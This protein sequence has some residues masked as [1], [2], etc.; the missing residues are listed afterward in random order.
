MQETKYG[1]KLAQE[2]YRWMIGDADLGNVLA[3]F[4]TS[5]VAPVSL[6][7]A[8]QPPLELRSALVTLSVDINALTQE[9]VRLREALEALNSTLFI[10]GNSLAPKQ[11]DVTASAPEEKAKE[12]ADG[13]VMSAIK[14]SG[15][16]LWD[17]FKSKLA[18]KAIDFVAGSL[19]KVFK[20]RKN[21][22]GRNTGLRRLFEQPGQALGGSPMGF[23][24]GAPSQNY[25]AF[26]MANPPASAANLPSGALT[27][28]LGKF[29][30]LGI[31]RLGPFR[32]AEAS[33]DVIQGV[34]N[35]DA[36][37]IGSGLS[38]AGG[39]WAGASAGAAIG[40]MVFPGVGTA[41]GGAIG[42]LLGSEAGAWIGDKLFGSSDRLPTPGAVSKELSSARTDNV[43]VTL[44]P[45]IQITGVNPAD[46]Q[47][48][49]NQVIQAL[50]FQCLPMFS[51]ALGIRRNAALA[52]SPGGD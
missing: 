24:S 8:A 10:N 42:G 23:H 36:H 22:S 6:D 50:Q 2:D 3:P 37:A 18:E 7:A 47:Q 34:R 41:V 15:G 19:G 49:V 11:A 4:S 52:D 43:Q 27:D 29:E 31:R 30:S 40:T 13:P 17:A 46:A 9:Q 20:G 48:V 45:S 5:A 21:I 51:D 44:A 39:A 16:E 26:A 14:E 25:P 12:P 1:I 28:A 33:L 38:T 32:V 35:G